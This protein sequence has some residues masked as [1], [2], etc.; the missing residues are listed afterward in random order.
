MGAGLAAGWVVA[1]LV[2][3]TLPFSFSTVISLPLVF[4]PVSLAVVTLALHHNALVQ[5]WPVH[6]Q[7]LERLVL[8]V[9]PFPAIALGWRLLVALLDLTGQSHAYLLFIL[10]AV[11]FA[12]SALPLQPSFSPH[13]GVYVQPSWMPRVSLCVLVASPALHYLFTYYSAMSL[14]HFLHWANLA[15]LVALPLIFLA[16]LAPHRPLWWT[17]T[18]FLSLSFS[19]FK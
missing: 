17:C 12:L 18:T 10:C 2:S 19:N 9:A 14:S 4:M 5:R 13:L 16:L 15:L 7:L 8:V 6:A 3:F 1:L 11:S